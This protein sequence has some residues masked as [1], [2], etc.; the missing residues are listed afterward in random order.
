M[1]SKSKRRRE[2]KQRAQGASVGQMT[3]LLQ[4]LAVAPAKPK[5]KRNRKRNPTAGT[6][7]QGIITLSRRELVGEISLAT[8]SPKAQGHW[9][10]VPNS[11]GFLKN[12]AQCFD[13]IKWLKLNIFYKPAV[14]T[15]YGGLIAVGMDWDFGSADVERSK[16][17]GFTPNFT[18]AA[19]ADTE[20]RPMVLPK[21]RLQSREW[22]TPNSVSSEWVD[23]GPG[24]LHW[25]A[26]GA[27]EKGGRVLGEIWVDYS[28]QMMGTNPA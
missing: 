20:N 27:S 14:G 17:A 28:V 16:I 12:L 26:S 19:W 13:R 5:R 15:V 11:F 6:S 2:A 1:V 25:A 21:N 3:N 8:D 22:Y 7:A 23:R 9:D 24:K 10:L 4:K 18:C